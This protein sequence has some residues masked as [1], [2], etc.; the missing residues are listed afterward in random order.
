MEEFKFAFLADMHVT[1]A[2]VLDG[3]LLNI[4]QNAESPFL[5]L[6]SAFIILN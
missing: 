6:H 4:M 1:S 5:I 2:T 3:G